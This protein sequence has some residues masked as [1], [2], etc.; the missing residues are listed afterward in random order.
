MSVPSFF[1]GIHQAPPI[2]VFSLS[3]ACREDVSPD[4]INL[5]VGAYRT[6]EGEPWVLPCVRA[7][8][9]SLAADHSLNKEYL[10]ITG[11]E[12]M[13][14][15]VL[16][17]LL[18][19]CCPLIAE[20]K[21]DNCQSLGGTGAV[22]LGLQ[23]LR[24]LCNRAVVFVSR[25]TWPNHIG[26][27]KFTGL[28]VR[29]YRYW[30]SATRSV[31]FEGMVEDL[32]EG[33]DGA[34]IILHACA[35]NPTGM[36]L[37]RKQWMDLLI[38]IKEKHLFPLFDL[39][40]Q[41]FASGDLDND[42]WA[43]RYFAEQGMELFVAQSFS[44]NFGLY[45]NSGTRNRKALQNSTRTFKLT[46]QPNHLAY[47]SHIKVLSSSVSKGQG[48]C[49]ATR[50]SPVRACVGGPGD[51]WWLRDDELSVQCTG[52][53]LTSFSSRPSPV[54]KPQDERVGALAFITK[55]AS[56][57]AKV[58]S[59]LKIII[60]QSWSNPPQHGA[61]IVGKILSDPVLTAEWKSNV[62]TMAERVKL[63]RQMLYDSLLK[64]N[65]PG[66]WDH[67]IQQIGMFSYTGLTKEQSQYMRDKHHVYLMNDGRINMCALTTHNVEYVAKVIHDALTELP[68]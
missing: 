6:N 13:C 40:Y 54:R 39:A 45:I 15:N 59:Q 14:A 42:A 12:A 31:N 1:E 52:V 32:R 62:F 68:D 27:S 63:M 29:E 56:I 21:A 60:R 3:E 25:P 17:L 30:D 46:S 23:F 50:T 22:F 35:H 9:T 55:D 57:T 26:I 7:V 20:K 67:I 66:S 33:P 10:P 61:L 53:L 18:G 34:V 43:V 2:E 8:E 41:G 51:Q 49:F 28:E 47:F 36:D 44:K 19:E 24:R 37:S 4:K 11:L 65:T 38:V 58:K 16:K 5:T 64:L 48:D